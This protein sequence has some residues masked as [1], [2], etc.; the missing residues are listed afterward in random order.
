MPGTNLSSSKATSRTL[1]PGAPGLGPISRLDFDTLLF[2]VLQH[3]IYRG[4]M[5]KPAL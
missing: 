2:P 3:F 5:T 4:V 1:A